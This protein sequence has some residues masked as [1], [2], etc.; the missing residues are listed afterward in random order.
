VILVDVNLLLYAT[1]S[2][3]PQHALAHAWLDDRLS[4]DGR[5]G[6][7]WPSLIAFLR[8][9]TNPRVFPR[10]MATETAWAQIEVWLGC[11]RVWC[12]SPTERHRSILAHLVEAGGAR[13][14]LVPDAHLAALAIEHGLE[15]CSADKDFARFPGLRWTNPLA[16]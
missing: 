16:H 15:L 12:P 1:V 11:D 4:E 6:L 7:P 8:L 13:G 3:F 10:P 14:E 5:V 2:T 9:V